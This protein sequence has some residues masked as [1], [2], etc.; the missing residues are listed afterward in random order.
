[1]AKV[2]DSATDL[3]TFARSSS[4]TALRR[5]GYGENLVDNDD[6]AT[7]DISA[8]GSFDG[9]L[10]VVGGQL[11]LTYTT[12]TQY[13]WVEV[14]TTPGTLYEFSIDCRSDNAVGHKLVAY[15]DAFPLGTQIA[16]NPPFVNF[17]ASLTTQTLRVRATT[18]T[19]LFM[20]STQLTSGTAYFDN[21]SVKEVIFDRATD[22]LV[23]FNHPDDIP[24]IEYGPDGSLK[25]LLIEEQRANLLTHSTPDAVTPTN[26]GALSG[27]GTRTL[28]T[29]SNGL[30]ALRFQATSERPY[31]QQAVTLNANTTYTLSVY[32]EAGYTAGARP[33]LLISNLGGTTGTTQA[34]LGSEDS[35]GRISVTFTT[36]SDVSGF[37]RYGLGT[38]T[39]DTGDVTLGG[40]QLEAGSFATSYIPTSGSQETRWADVASI[41]VSAFGYNQDAGTV[42]VEASAYAGNPINANY[43]SFGN[44]ALTDF[45]RLWTWEGD[46]SSVRWTGT[47]FDVT[48]SFMAGTTEVMAGAY[49]ENNYNI[50]LDG[51]A[52]TPDTAGAQTLDAT[53]VYLGSKTGAT[54]FLNGH[55]KS[56]QYYPRRLT[57]TQLQELTS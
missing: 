29:L 3:I 44:A 24:R 10:A 7:T 26:W 51:S 21:V 50:A 36:G 53:L 54:E 9:T 42:V 23:L 18:S 1:M 25:G 28:T 46:T 57:N 37:I 31:I 34:S 6:F 13:V 11:E 27:S 8:W 48:R 19:T 56:I 22:P 20:V 4:G 38:D 49:A 30:S 40:M 15:S 17:S 5:I 43:C 47:N 12:A 45:I 55:I 35:N 52:A 39:N 2:H 33:V 14:T 32:V 41:P 16:P